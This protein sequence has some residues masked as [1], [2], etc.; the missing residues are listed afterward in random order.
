MVV[1]LFRYRLGKVC[2]SHDWSVA[3]PPDSGGFSVLGANALFSG[4]C[5]QLEWLRQLAVIAKQKGRSNASSF[6]QIKDRGVD[7]RGSACSRREPGREL[8]ARPG[9]L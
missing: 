3:E 6:L 2:V 5:V 4:R 9:D 8:G 7:D 1:Q